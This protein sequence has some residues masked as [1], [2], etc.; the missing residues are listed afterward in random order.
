MK[1]FFLE[2]SLKFWLKNNYILHLFALLQIGVKHNIYS[3]AAQGRPPTNE[4]VSR[5]KP[6]R[7]IVAIRRMPYVV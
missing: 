7:H 2:N 3:N 4:G 1:L 5:K 6:D